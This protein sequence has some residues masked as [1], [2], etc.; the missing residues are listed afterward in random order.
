[1]LTTPIEACTSFQEAAAVCMAVAQA[2]AD[3]HT[4]ASAAWLAGC[5]VAFQQ[6]I[7]G[8]PAK[9]CSLAL[10]PPLDHFHVKARSRYI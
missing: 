9:V 6:A 2:E 8:R 7:S 10:T 1:M 5:S 4:I 3:H